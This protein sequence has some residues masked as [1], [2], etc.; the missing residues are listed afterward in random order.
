VLD[1][2]LRLIFAPLT[3]TFRRPAEERSSID[4]PIVRR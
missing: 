2:S 3:T 1:T 4:R